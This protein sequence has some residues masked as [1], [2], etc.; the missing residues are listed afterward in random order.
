VLRD[1]TRAAGIIMH[2]AGLTV[3]LERRLHAA[4]QRSAQIRASRWRIVAAQDSERRELE[5]D[6]HDGAQPG[7]TAIRFALGLIAHLVRSGREQ[8]AREAFGHLRDQMDA[9][10]AGLHQILRG[11]DPPALTAEGIIP[12]L[13]EL[14]ESLGTTVTFH[15]GAEAQAA[16]FSA[17]IEAAVYFCTAEAIQNTV[18]HCPGAPVTVGLDL[19]QDRDGVGSVLRFTITDQGPGFEARGAVSEGGGLQNMT[20]RVN[21]VAGTLTITSTL[22]VGTEIVGTV[23]AVARA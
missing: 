22:G 20:D 16:R 17:Q 23:P 15:V 8:A 3:E 13:R 9:A 6:L 5:R 10:S 12:A 7:L 14:A 1:L 18:K 2:N 4:E 11:L 19:D 21:A